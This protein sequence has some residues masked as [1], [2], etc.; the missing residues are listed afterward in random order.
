MN[1]QIK[2]KLGEGKFSKVYR[3]HYN[4]NDYALKK[5]N[6]SSIP[7][8]QKKYIMCELKILA[9]H[10]CKYIINFYKAFIANDDICIIMDY[11]HNGTL[12]NYIKTHI[13]ISPTIIWKFFSQICSGLSYLHLNNIIHRDLK[14][15][16]ILIDSYNNI[17]LIDFGVSK[18]LN[19]Y[20]TFTKSFV[21][22]PQCMSPE[23]MKNLYYDHKVD[24][25][26]LGIVLYE[27]THNKLPFVCKNF[28]ELH[29][30]IEQC[31]YNVRNDIDISFKSIINRCIQS[32]PH[33]RIKLNALLN[34]PEIKKHLD[35][36]KKKQKKNITQI[37]KIPQMLSDWKDELKNFPN[38][39]KENPPE[40]KMR[41]TGDFL[42]HYSKQDLVYLNITLV[43]EIIAK[44]KIIKE[45]KLK[46]DSY[47][48]IS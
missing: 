29:L 3:I 28:E 23:I 30:K 14:S 42:D 1:Y 40:N 46:L 37:N 35:I 24:I 13:N 21:G 39:I 34:H 8:S 31:K 47:K 38:K 10:S 48:V 32:S 18:I 45:L 7:N 41:K 27:L 17:K 2:D 15:S 36:E 19:N 33:K 4:K 6:L 25:W 12:Q 26:S 20:M 5:I 9:T 11:C 43:D 16:N 22:T 44:N